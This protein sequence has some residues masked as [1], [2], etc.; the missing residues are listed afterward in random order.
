MARHPSNAIT[1]ERCSAEVA[2]LKY[3]HSIEATLQAS[4]DA[5]YFVRTP[6]CYLYDD[7]AKTQIQEYLAGTLDLKSTVLKG[8]ERPLDK[9]L[10]QQYHHIGR[11]LA[12]YI[13]QFHQNTSPVARAHAEKGTSPHPSTLHEAIS[14]SS[15]MQDLKLMVN[16]D[17]LLERVEQFPDILKDAKDVFVRLRE[18]GIDELKNGSAASTVIHGDFCPQNILIRD[19][20]PRDGKETSL[21]VVDWE[22]AQIGVPAMDHGEMIGELYSTWLYDGS[23]AGIHVIEGYAAGLGSLPVDVALRIAAQVGV[24]L[25]SFGTLAQDKS[26]LQVDH[27]AREGRDIIVNSCKKNQ[28]WFRDHVLRC[29]FTR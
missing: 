28:S 24:H 29:L 2:C 16:Y 22:N 18:Q 4:E 25:L 20:S 5:K 17:W 15:E 14:R 19:E 10:Q 1:I 8:C 27:V 3:L 13:S 26:E 11:A 12:E 6:K 9:L 7:E 23:D 21:F